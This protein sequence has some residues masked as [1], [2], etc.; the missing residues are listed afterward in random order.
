MYMINLK[1]NVYIL[2][3]GIFHLLFT[4]LIVSMIRSILG[5]PG[6]VP[7]YWGFFA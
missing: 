6:R 5:D 1:P 3:L 4:L 7:I 2:L